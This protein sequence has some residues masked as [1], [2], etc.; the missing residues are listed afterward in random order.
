MKPFQITIP[1]SDLVDKVN[2]FPI[3]LWVLLNKEDDEYLGLFTTLE[4]E[5][6]IEESEWSEE[7]PTKWELVELT[8]RDLLYQECNDEK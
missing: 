2:D 5:S 8:L 7:S 4:K 1:A 6:H 3:V